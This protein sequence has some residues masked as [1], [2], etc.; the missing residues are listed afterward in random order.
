[1][2]NEA[3]PDL[4]E[5]IAHWERWV[6]VDGPALEPWWW[7]FRAFRWDVWR[8][9]QRHGPNRVALRVGRW[10]RDFAP[11]VVVR[12]RRLGGSTA[13]LSDTAESGLEAFAEWGA[14]YGASGSTQSVAF[15]VFSAGVGVRSVA[16]PTGTVTRPVG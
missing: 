16:W 9:R 5:I 8:R 15:P 14:R 3:A 10:R 11:A 13:T 2:G 4:E 12:H 7:P 6:A 1:M